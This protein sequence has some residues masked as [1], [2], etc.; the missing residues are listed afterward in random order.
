MYLSHNYKTR[1]SETLGFPRSRPGL[2]PSPG[3]DK[4]GVQPLCS[5]ETNLLNDPKSHK[6]AGRMPM[7]PYDPNEQTFPCRV[8][9]RHFIKSSLV[10][11]ESACK[12]LQ[13]LN[14]KVFDSGKQRAQGSDVPY[15]A[16][17]KAQK[18]KEKF[19]GQFPRPKTHWRERHEEFIGAVSASKQ[20]EHALKTGAPLPPPPRTSLPSDSDPGPAETR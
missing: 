7:N 14:R 16:I 5:W 4:L 8:C 2:D 19:G 10:K 15:A 11:H 17:K 18:E 3:D 9:G 20:V 1:W 13:K 6:P 12:K